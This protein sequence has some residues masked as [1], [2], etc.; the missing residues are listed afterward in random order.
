MHQKLR[1]ACATN[2]GSFDLLQLRTTVVTNWGNYYKLGQNVLPVGAG[3]TNQGNYYK[4]GHNSTI[5]GFFTEL[6]LRKKK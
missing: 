3:I 5:E 4:L 6:K 2:W 1:Q